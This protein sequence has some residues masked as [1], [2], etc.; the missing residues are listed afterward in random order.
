MST[1]SSL[2][3]KELGDKFIHV[4]LDVFTKKYFIEG[5]KFKKQI[6][7]KQAEIT[8]YFLKNN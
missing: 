7:K 2:A 4:Y 6:S 3:Y 5:E 1:K 8:A